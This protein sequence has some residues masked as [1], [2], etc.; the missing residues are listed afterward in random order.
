MMAKPSESKSFDVAIPKTWRRF[1]PKWLHSLIWLDAV[2]RYDAFLSYSWNADR[3]I[4]PVLQYVLQKFLCPWYKMRAKTIFRD[5]SALPA[6]SDLYQE[7]FERIDRST[8]FI[9]LA[10]PAVVHSKG[11]EAE[12]K[13]WFSRPRDGKTII[14]VTDGEPASWE[15]IRKGFLPP[16]MAAQLTR[17]PLWVSVCHRRAEML[18]NPKSTLLRAQLVEDLQ[19]VFLRLYDPQTWE[20]LQ[21]EER[22]QRRKTVRLVSTAA[23]VFL[24]LFVA[25]TVLGIVAESERVNA[26]AKQLI[27]QA[28]NL[29][30]SAP[31][32]MIHSVSLALESERLNASVEADA[33]LRK[34]IQLLA[35]PRIAVTHDTELTAMAVS[36]DEQTVA[37]GDFGGLVKVWSSANGKV[38]FTINLS[39]SVNAIDFSPDSSSF[40]TAGEDKTTRLW[41]AKSGQPIANLPVAGSAEKVLFAPD[42]KWIA[43][44]TFDGDV[45]LWNW[46]TGE[47]FSF[48]FSGSNLR[49][50]TD[51]KFSKDGTLLFASSR[52]GHAGAFD[53]PTRREIAHVGDGDW[54]LSLAV[55]KDGSAFATAGNGEWSNV[56]QSRGGKLLAHF[57]NG[58][59]CFST[60]FSPDDK[61]LAVGCTDKRVRVWN[62]PENR[63]EHLLEVNNLAFGVSFDHTGNYL[64]VLEGPTASLRNIATE[65]EVRRV[66]HQLGIIDAHLTAD[67]RK[68]ISASS[69]GTAR[70]WDVLAD[71]ELADMYQPSEVDSLAFDPTNRRIAIA[72]DDSVGLWSIADG[73]M[74][75]NISSNADAVDFDKDG[76][77]LAVGSSDGTVT[78][79]N[80]DSGG[81]VVTP[82]GATHKIVETVRFSPDAKFLASGGWDNQVHL[83][84]VPSGGNAWNSSS[85]P[86]WIMALAFSPDGQLIASGCMDGI[87]RILSAVSGK[88]VQ[89]FEHGGQIASVAF[90]P[91]GKVVASASSDG[92]ARLRNL[93]TSGEMGRFTHSGDVSGVAFSPDGRL[94]ATSSWDQTAR[95]W[96]LSDR[97]EIARIPHGD[98]VKTV[99]FSPDG[100]YVASASGKRVMLSDIRPESVKPSACSLLTANLQPEEWRLYGVNPV[101]PGLCPNVP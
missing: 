7:L 35:R 68:L 42:G 78:M 101:Q 66:T 12:A 81:L 20:E 29:T 33:I 10:S 96:R 23:A 19:Q 95:I 41:S 50:I 62:L 60:A 63:L 24:V 89:H 47:K 100:R 13:H 28:E 58:V 44:G 79:W 17:E 31:A 5:L 3:E 65:T 27:A 1:L 85:F 97:Q 82:E 61:L 67:D 80:A 91:D 22:S 8:H 84:H 92:T 98:A 86:N 9:V 6:G 59:D 38:I 88:E 53:L 43:T 90:S 37:T 21:G 76:K 87:V 93:S 77:W 73:K 16:T 11:M 70:I 15:E 48:S 25:A 49:E 2:S 46:Q 34:D 72:D 4:A 55:T 40:T 54:I 32:Q 71:H 14:I 69:D 52:D 26:L 45:V 74:I 36:P 57:Y 56:Y 75:R 18:A 64:L 51:L 94:L 99:A 83:W 39:K 30:Q